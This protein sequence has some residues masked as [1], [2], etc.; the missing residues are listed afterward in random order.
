M[1][2]LYT[3]FVILDS[4]WKLHSMFL[5]VLIIISFT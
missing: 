2:C 3:S 4:A 5:T 1:Y